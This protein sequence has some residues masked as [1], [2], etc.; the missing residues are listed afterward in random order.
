MRWLNSIADSIDINLSKHEEIVGA[1]LVA[2]TVKNLSAMPET[3]V[4]LLGWEEH[5]EKGMT[6]HSSIL[7]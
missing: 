7:A 3:Q 4:Q 6:T 2:Q 5:L 1:S